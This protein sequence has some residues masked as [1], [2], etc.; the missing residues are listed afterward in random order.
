MT[1][2]NLGP[3]KLPFIGL[4]ALAF[5]FGINHWTFT[6]EGRGSL[7]LLIVCPLFLPFFIGGIVEPRI[8]YA[9]R[10]G[11]MRIEAK[12]RWMAMGL[13]VLGAGLAAWMALGLYHV[14]F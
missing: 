10:S 8:Y 7:T 3:R 5:G 14:T 13:I 11:P 4:G 1:L 9:L 6:S 12:Y 2:N